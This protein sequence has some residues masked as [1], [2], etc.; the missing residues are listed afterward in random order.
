[1]IEADLANHQTQYDTLQTGHLDICGGHVGR[2]DYYRCHVA[3][4]CMT[5]QMEN[6]GPD[7]IISRAFDGFPIYGDANPDG[8]ATAEEVLDACIGQTDETFGYRYPTSTDAPYIVQC[9]IGAVTGFDSPPGVRPLPAAGGG[10]WDEL[11]KKLSF[12]Q[13]TI[14]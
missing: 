11:A 12:D 2:G 7:A 14:C 3:P 9:L 5:E 1:M 6:A 8:S 10:R 13:D 4:V